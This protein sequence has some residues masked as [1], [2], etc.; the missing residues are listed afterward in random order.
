MSQKKS[1][2]KTRIAWAGLFFIVAFF[3]FYVVSFAPSKT[4]PSDSIVSIHSGDTIS[5]IA[6]QFKKVGLVRS[7]FYFK[8]L[9]HLFGRSTGV[10][11]GKYYFHEPLSVF[12]VVNR[13]LTGAY[14]IKEQKVLIPEG[15][16]VKDIADKLALEFSD[17]D[18]ELFLRL[19]KDKEGYLFPDT[20]SWLPDVSPTQVLSDMQKNFHKKTA[21]LSQDVASFGKPLKDV[22]IMASLLEKEAR[23]METR[24][25]VAGILWKRIAIGMPLQVDA[26]FGYI[27]KRDTY[28]PSFADLKVDSP[29]NTYMHKDLPPGPISNPGLD[30]I[31]AAITPTVSPYLYYLS[32]K[33]GNM[34]YARTFAEHVANKERYLR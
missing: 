25:I 19:A 32:D 1:F 8:L 4:F 31:V 15:F 27:F 34:H 17:F 29:Y 33:E 23:Q 6:A 9:A 20:Y 12:S 10:I 14:D 18:R 26:V 2:Y 28:S 7:E 16:T 3:I 5:E 24:K 13:V 30:A 22:V 21:P 11:A